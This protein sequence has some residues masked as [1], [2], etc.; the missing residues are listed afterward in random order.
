VAA[1]RNRY[2]ELHL[3]ILIMAGS[4]DEIVNGERQSSRLHS[5]LP[6]S[7]LV[8]IEGAGHMVHHAAPQRV[9]DAI[10]AMLSR[11]NSAGEPFTIQPSVH[12]QAIQD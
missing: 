1:L 7:E 9:A 2:G 10:R 12:L 3:P 8:W 5:K 6:T 4:K 11:P